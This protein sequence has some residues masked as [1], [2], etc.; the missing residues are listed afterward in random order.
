MKKTMIALCFSL[1][2]IVGISS[3]ACTYP[4]QVGMYFD[5]LDL[6]TG[7]VEYDRTILVVLMGETIEEL[8]RPE[9]TPLARFSPPVDVS[10]TFDP[11]TPGSFELVLQDS[12]KVAVLEDTSFDTVGN[13]HFG[14]L[15][16]TE[17]PFSVTVDSN[18]LVVAMTAEDRYFMLGNFCQTDWELQFDVED[19]S[20][21]EPGTLLL[22]GL[23]LIGMIRIVRRKR[24]LVAMLALFLLAGLWCAETGHAQTDPLITVKKEGTGKGTILFGNQQCTLDC[25]EFILS[26]SEGT[27]AILKAIPDAESR[28][29]RWK[30]EDGSSAEGTLKVH[31]GDTVIA[32]FQNKR[33]LFSDDPNFP[34]SPNVSDPI[35]V[36]GRYVQ[37]FPDVL[38]NET[39]VIF[40]VF[41]DVYVNAITEYV[42]VESENQYVWSGSISGSEWS[43]ATIVVEY[44]S[45]VGNI[46]HN[47]KMY[48]IRP[49]D[50]GGHA[51]FEIDQSA[52][53]D[54]A[55][56]I[57]VS[58]NISPPESEGLSVGDAAVS[59]VRNVL[60]LFSANVAYAQSPT[61]DVMVLYTPA[62]KKEAGGKEKDIVAAI[63]LAI[64][65]TNTTYANSG[66]Y[67]RLQLVH[68]KE[69]SYQEDGEDMEKDLDNLTNTSDGNMDDIH[70]LRKEYMADLVS[71]WIEK[72]DYCG[73]GYIMTNVSNSFK[74][75][76]F[77]VVKR[78]CA[79]GNLSFAHELGHNMAA[80]HDW[81]ADNKNN[82]PYTYNHG[83]VNKT[84]S[85]RTVMAYNDKC[86][87]SNEADPCPVKAKRKTPGKPS[88]TRQKFWSN[89]DKKYDNDPTGVAEGKTDAADNRKTLNNTANTVAGFF[90]SI[91]TYT[92]TASASPGGSISPTGTVTV[93]KGA[94][95]TFTI[96][97]NAGYR[98]KEVLVN[99]VSNGVITMYTFTNVQANQTIQANFELIPQVF[100]QITATAGTGASISPFGI[101]S[102]KEGANQTF[103]MAPQAG[104]QI[105]DV[106]VDGISQGVLTSYTFS[107][108]QTNHKIDCIAEPNPCQVTNGYDSG[109][110]SLRQ[111]L[112]NAGGNGCATITFAPGVST[113]ALN[114]QLEIPSGTLTIDGGSSGVI[115][116]GQNRTRV[117]YIGSN[118]KV[119]LENLTITEG[120]VSGDYV[121]LGGYAYGAGIYNR[122][123]L[124][125]AS[126]SI[127]SNN[128]ITA[129]TLSYGGGIFN[130]RGI[131]T[132][133][134]TVSNNTIYR[135]MGG[136]G[137]YNY[138]GEIIVNGKITGN[139]SPG[140]AGMMNYF[141]QVTINPT[142]RVENNKA[143]PLDSGGSGMGGGIYNANGGVLLVKG[144]VSGN[145]ATD[146]G[147]GIYNIHMVNIENGGIIRNNTAAN[148]GGGIYSPGTVSGATTSN[149]FSNIA[150]ASNGCDNYFVWGNSGGCRW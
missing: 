50:E 48:A 10:F 78:S 120:N 2:L 83:Y 80:R 34:E 73:L 17:L 145:T 119:I 22:F 144:T 40:N 66:I 114:S 99:G 19:L 87:C 130:Y 107:N 146:D 38:K 92:I 7:A 11:A 25:Q 149:L 37:I 122:G 76:A 127:V 131:V 94:S 93:N 128:A 27:A 32:L 82:S 72:G 33:E 23:G 138:E 60:S 139:K 55:P 132:L 125:I 74:D 100:Y 16:L 56:P 101:V 116:S 110:G 53:Q 109:I 26:Y 143:T 47:G 67:P 124:T 13:I 57:Q 42:K 77:T 148:T 21:P 111:V 95:R 121:S 6:D 8:L 106:L 89:P 103:T 39:E 105:K 31:P 97:P 90:S 102:V 36:R 98:I 134:G 29:V 1:L 104:Y 129:K 118:A 52:F 117:F 54:E 44:D 15:E 18:D 59:L 136:G 123:N 68:T 96:T 142:G 28:F 133:N 137:I 71:L 24:R 5:G 58:F 79:V 12:V 9:K 88:C 108:V 35:F 75:S 141:G 51:V 3:T 61:I 63:K 81:Y 86:D 135:Y 69:V 113:I 14:K 41:E 115:I 49:V 65:E 84:K 91:E 46:R 70:T 126:S 4:A 85:W 30:P 140:G 62:A 147:G 43:D 150:L 64:A 45:V 20:V 112:A